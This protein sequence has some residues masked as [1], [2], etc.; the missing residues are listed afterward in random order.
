MSDKTMTAVYK[1]KYDC[2]HSRR[3]AT[4]DKDFPIRDVYMLKPAAASVEEFELTIKVTS[5]K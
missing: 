2:K 1:P 3:F 4:E 5:T